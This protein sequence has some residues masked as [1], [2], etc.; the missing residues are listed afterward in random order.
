MEVEMAE[1]YD[2]LTREQLLEEAKNRELSGLSSA[3]KAE[4]V[5]ALE[6]YDDSYAEEDQ[7]DEPAEPVEG[8][9]EEPVD[10]EPVEEAPKPP[11]LEERREKELEAAKLDAEVRKSQGEIDWRLVEAERIHE[12]EEKEPDGYPDGIIRDGM[13]TERKASPQVLAGED[14]TADPQ[15]GS[16]A[17]P[18]TNLG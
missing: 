14:V 13:S 4:L 9:A 7:S 1:D 10:S 16:E 17:D 3:T 8:D 12:E 5:A 15:A 11:T 6:A 18:A 2:S